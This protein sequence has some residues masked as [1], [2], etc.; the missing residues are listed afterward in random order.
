MT[1]D[2]LFILVT[3]LT[4]HYLLYSLNTQ[5][6]LRRDLPALQFND[7]K[8]MKTHQQHIH[9]D[10]CMHVSLPSSSRSLLF[11]TSNALIGTG[12]KLRRMP[13]FRWSEGAAGGMMQKASRP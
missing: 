12:N 5:F 11:S 6:A 3:V 9:M 7:Q 1:I 2:Y 10:E 8:S 13:L 4:S